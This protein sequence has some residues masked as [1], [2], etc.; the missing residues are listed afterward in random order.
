MEEALG[1]TLDCQSLSWA[2]QEEDIKQN[3]QNEKVF[4]VI[5]GD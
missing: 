2:K 4:S 5:K 3:R 1:S